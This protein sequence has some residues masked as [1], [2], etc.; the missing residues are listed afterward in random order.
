MVLI[1]EDIIN[2]NKTTI[3]NPTILK[4]VCP[5]VFGKIW[6]SLCAILKVE[7]SN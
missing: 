6:F 4:K 7:V 2:D 5:G 3:G 1:C